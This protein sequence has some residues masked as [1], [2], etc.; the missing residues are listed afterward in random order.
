MSCDVIVY[1]LPVIQSC[2]YLFFYLP[3][4]EELAVELHLDPVHGLLQQQHLLTLTHGGHALLLRGGGGGGGASGVGGQGGV[5]NP[6]QR[7][8]G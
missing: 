5:G 2:S 6:K 3:E 7:V 1:A 8:A 4:R